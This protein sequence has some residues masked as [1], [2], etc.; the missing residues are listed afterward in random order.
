MQQS[1]RTL[2]AV[3]NKSFNVTCNCRKDEGVPLSSLTGPS[4]RKPVRKT[5]GG[6]GSRRRMGYGVLMGYGAL[7]PTISRLRRMILMHLGFRRCEW[8]GQ[9]N[10]RR[11]RKILNGVGRTEI[12]GR[13]KKSGTD[14]RIWRLVTKQPTKEAGREE[15]ENGGTSHRVTAD[16]AG[17]ATDKADKEEGSSYDAGG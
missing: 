16:V 3:E 12:S 1:K 2:S 5:G 7:M 10:R 9:G 11:W 4:A 14:R 6:L 15:G 8:A 17:T 13:A